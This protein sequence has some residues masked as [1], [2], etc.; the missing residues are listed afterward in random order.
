MT[1]E[2]WNPDEPGVTVQTF[3]GTE[4]DF[5]SYTGKPDEWCP[6]TDDEEPA[7]CKRQSDS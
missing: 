6:E 3:D 2:Q 7:G 5:A 4:V 1:E